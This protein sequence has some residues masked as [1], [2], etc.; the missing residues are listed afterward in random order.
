MKQTPGPWKLGQVGDTVITN[1][2]TPSSPHVFDHYG[3][4]V[5]AESISS[6]A[7]RHLISAAPELFTALWRLLEWYDDGV[8]TYEPDCPPE[9]A[10]R[11]E[12]ARM[13]QLELFQNRRG[14]HV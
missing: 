7:D 14:F 9:E 12:Q 13:A 8:S 6:D 4:Q 5:V 3:G 10:K 2:E 1:A 11:W